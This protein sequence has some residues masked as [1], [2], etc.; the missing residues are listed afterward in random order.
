MGA[1]P[2]GW[3]AGEGWALGSLALANPPGEAPPGA[4][5]GFQLWA[6]GSHCSLPPGTSHPHTGS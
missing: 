1:E 3:G 2:Q 6:S 4:G 5:K